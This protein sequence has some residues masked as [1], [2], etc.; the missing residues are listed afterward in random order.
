MADYVLLVLRRLPVD[1]TGGVI[2]AMPVDDSPAGRA[3]INQDTIT[4]VTDDAVH[5]YLPIS[6]RAERLGVLDA[7]L[8][9]PPDADVLDTLE[10]AGDRARVP[11]AGCSQRHRHRGAGAAGAAA[12][13]AGGDAV[14]DAADP[15]VKLRSVQPGRAA[16]PGVRRRR[17]PVRLRRGHRRAVRLGDRR[18]GPRVAGQPARDAR[19]HYAAQRAADRPRARPPAPAS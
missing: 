12:G 16:G 18:D 9:E 11:A 13:A 6:V 2:E 10:P 8:R 4:E 1:M 15:G 7:V 19:G 17:R 3:F 14:V 5:V